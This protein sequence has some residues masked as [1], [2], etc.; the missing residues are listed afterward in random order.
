[1]N[2]RTHTEHL[3]HFDCPFAAGQ[4]LIKVEF[5]LVIGTLC[6]TP[7]DPD[8]CKIFWLSLWKLAQN[9]NYVHFS[10][11]LSHNVL[12]W[13]APMALCHPPKHLVGEA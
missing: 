6:G 1:M 7:H 13:K 5:G 4:T 2:V 3:K 12:L 8:I 11:E 9:K 10:S